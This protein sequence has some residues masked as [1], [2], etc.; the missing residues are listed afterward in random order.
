MSRPIGHEQARALA[1]R[2]LD[3]VLPG[4]D[5]AALDGHLAGCSACTAVAAGYE[6]DRLALRELPPIEPPRDLWARTRVGLEHEHA[7][8][9]KVA[10][11]LPRRWGPVAGLGTG[12]ALVLVLVIVGPTLI[13]PRPAPGIALASTGPAGPATSQPEVTPIAVDAQV[14]WVVTEGPQ[15][16][17]IVT[18]DMTGVCPT[19]DEP[20]CAP[21]VGVAKSLGNLPTVPSAVTLSPTD[22]SQAIAAGP[23]Q[24][25][26]GTSLYVLSVPESPAGSPSPAPSVAP[27]TTTPSAA[28]SAS[29]ASPLPS[30]GS[31]ASASPSPRTSAPATA[32]PS[33]PPT[34][35]PV[36]TPRPSTSPTARPTSSPTAAPSAP[37]SPASSTTS[38][39]SQA[40]TTAIVSN[41][42]LVGDDA[43]YSKDGQWFAFSARPAGSAVGP[44]VYVWRAGWPSARAITSDHATVFAGWINGQILASRAMPETGPSPS[45]A[46]GSASPASPSPSDSPSP[47][48]SSSPSPASSVVPS[49]P[50]SPAPASTAASASPAGPVELASPAA[51]LID[52]ASGHATR[53]AGLD[54]WRPVVDPSG[55]WVA[56]WSGT[57]AFDPA[58]GGWLPFQGQLEIASWPVV[59]A[60]ADAVTGAAAGHALPFSGVIDWDLRWDSAGLHLGTWIGDPDN[61]GVGS[62]SLLTI[63]PATGLPSTTSPE[64]LGPTPAQRGFTLKD[65]QLVW[66]SPA[67]QDGLGSRLN[68]LAWTGQNAGKTTVQPL[69]GGALIVVH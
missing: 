33:G 66:A 35:S 68:I 67:G 56:Y 69:N 48:P 22:G 2:R 21:V 24:D 47:S 57:L 60:A 4:T 49:A 27:A 8:G 25:Q 58:S 26:A 16:P 12:V 51:F 44:D 36:A 52:P 65:G 17:S 15:G 37:A 13:G 55:R 5:E 29:P 7:H 41:V 38:A 45:S 6:A 9:P 54:G 53:I 30:T 10:R 64:L 46:Q 28:S 31:E 32:T 3:E 39:P 63:D 18:A 40:A 11:R 23:S 42:V 34:P 14:Q 59:S 1:A 61:P 62:L 19:G 20:A 50:S 43:A